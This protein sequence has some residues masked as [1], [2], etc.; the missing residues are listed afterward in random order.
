MRLLFLLS[1]ILLISCGP[2]NEKVSSKDIK[3]YL[4]TTLFIVDVYP[5]DKNTAYLKAKKNDQIKLYYLL[6]EE[7]IPVRFED[8]EKVYTDKTMK[9]LAQHVDLTAWINEGY[10]I[11]KILDTVQKITRK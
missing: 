2:E 1:F 3:S 4:D 6:R 9:Y 10:S 7:A 11:E 5:L 8:N